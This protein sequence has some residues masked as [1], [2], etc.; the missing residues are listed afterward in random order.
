MNNCDDRR[1]FTAQEKMIAEIVTGQTGEADHITPYSQGGKTDIA[2]LQ[3]IPASANK[4]KGSFVFKPRE[5]QAEFL[6]KWENRKPNLPF[7]LIAIPGSGKTMAAL[8]SARRW[9]NAGADRQIIVVVPTDNLRQQ[10]EQEA[11]QFGLDLQTKEFATS[12]KEGYQGAVT[13]Y[14]TVAG[15]QS[16]FRFLC[17]RPTMVIFDEIHHCGEEKHFGIGIKNAFENTKEKLLMSGTPW[18]TEGD[19]IPFVRYDSNGFAIGDY[20]YDYPSALNDGVVRHLVFDYA[21]GSI[22][23]EMNGVQFEMHGDISETDAAKRLS[24]LLDANGDFVRQ[25][26]IDSHNKLLEVRKVQTDAAALAICIDQTHAQKVAD[27]IESVTGRKPSVIVSDQDLNNDSVK[28]FRN[29]NTEWLV[30]VKKISEGVDIKRLQVLCYLTNV[31]SQLF[32]RQVIGR[33]SRVRDLDDYE[34]YIYLPADPRLIAAAK[35]IEN[36]QA[37]ALREAIEKNITE[38]VERETQ[39]RPPMFFTTSHDGTETVMM[40]SEQVDLAAFKR[41]EIIAQETKM[42]TKKVAEIA[43]LLGHFHEPVNATETITNSVAPAKTRSEREK[44]LRAECS[45]RAYQLSKLIDEDVAKI[46]AQYGRQQSMSLERLENKINDLKKRVTD[47][48][49]GAKNA[50]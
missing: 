36:A 9:R 39:D 34:G 21:K 6:T 20:A 46:H 30:S 37:Q 50:K 12:F 10:W 43:K 1:F 28:A 49:Q 35:N 42:P 27:I 15:N 4:K 48:R 29:S 33:V 41:F 14:Q 38:Q 31:T 19:A 8:E 22:T 25:Q 18:K 47:A 3:I 40:G 26:I 5:W 45:K 24:I 32:F 2:N 17:S 13:T 7:M 11:C 44:E 16:Q 23:N